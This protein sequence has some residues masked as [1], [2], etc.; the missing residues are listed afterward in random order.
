MKVKENDIILHIKSGRAYDVRSLLYGDAIAFELLRLEQ[1]EYAT[2]VRFSKE[3]L[4]SGEFRVI[5]S[6][7]RK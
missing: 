6:V 1:L 7:N 4:Q 3:Q 5:G 2:F